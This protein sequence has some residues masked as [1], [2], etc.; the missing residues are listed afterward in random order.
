M[1]NVHNYKQAT[2]CR[3]SRRDCTGQN[4]IK[5]LVS[6]GPDWWQYNVRPQSTPSCVL[7]PLVLT[8]PA[9]SSQTARQAATDTEVPGEA[10]VQ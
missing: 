10:G 1:L 4:L 2:R 7:V 3:P 8:E 9:G 6:V 5:S